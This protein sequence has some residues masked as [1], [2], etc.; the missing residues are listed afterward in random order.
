MSTATDMLA[1]YMAA[2]AA[3]LSGKTVTVNGRTLAQENLL[4]VRRG[5]QEW[6]RRV[7]AEQGGAATTVGG[8]GYAVANF[9]QREG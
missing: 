6:E 2:E 5:R 3:I 8:L 9:G 1:A 7:A 4:E